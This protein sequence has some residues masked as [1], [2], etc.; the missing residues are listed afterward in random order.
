MSF[1]P[2][3]S[4]L[5][6]LVLSLLVVR[7]ATVALALTGLSQQLARFQARSA[8]TGSGFT[9][10]ESEKVVAHPVRRRIIMVLMLL[11]NAAIIRSRKCMQNRAT[12]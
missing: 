6:V 8:F 9:T 4:L 2:I 11:G 7:I 5:V 10:A 1:V 3:I 12:G